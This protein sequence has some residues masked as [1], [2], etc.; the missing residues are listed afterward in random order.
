[1][2]VARTVELS[3]VFNVDGELHALEP[4]RVRGAEAPRRE[5]LLIAADA[6]LVRRLPA[7][8]VGAADAR[9]V[10][11]IH[12]EAAPHEDALEAF[13]AVPAVLPGDGAR[14]VPHQ[15]VHGARV[16]RDLIV[17]DAV[18]AMQRLRSGVAEHG[19]TDGERAL[20]LDDERLRGGRRRGAG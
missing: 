17:D 5:V 8:P 18:I 7:A 20:P 16:R 12:R 6:G 10:P 1:M 14:A 3:Q 9:A 19:A 15:K 11:E 2:S 13:A 4:I